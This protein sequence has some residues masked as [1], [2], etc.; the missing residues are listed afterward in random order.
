MRLPFPEPEGVTVHQLE[1]L[2]AVHPIFEVTVKIVAAAGVEGTFW[3]G[4]VTERLGGEA[5]W[6]TV[7]TTGVRPATVTVICATLVIV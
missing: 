6:V 3:L 4:G 1:L 7:T 5:A 2:I